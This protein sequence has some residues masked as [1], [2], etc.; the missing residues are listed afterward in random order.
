MACR[1]AIGLGGRP[2]PG[3]A[4]SRRALFLDRDGIV[5]V[6]RG[7]VGRAQDFEFVDGIFD[8]CR[9]AGAQGYVPI[10]VTNQ[11]GIARGFY[12]EADFAALTRWM[13]EEFLSRGV[14][15]ARVYYCPHHPSAGIDPY[16][17]PCDSRKPGPGMLLAA[18]DECGLDLRESVLIG[19]Q[20]SDA[21]AALG[22]RL[23]RTVIV[24]PPDRA[25]ELP[26]GAV[27]APSLHAAKAMLL[28]RG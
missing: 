14:E 22:V 8:L 7:Y 12:T 27:R 15:V 28:D 10:V 19:D 18:R 1:P 13:L 6:D 26:A 25:L 4:G 17:V 2:L 24:A 3:R 20:P 16:R 21:A 11:A 23:G 9:E 5:N